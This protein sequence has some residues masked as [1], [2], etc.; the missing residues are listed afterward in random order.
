MS[1]MKLKNWKAKLIE[2]VSNMKQI[3]TYMISSNMKR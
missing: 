3:N 2:M 1:E